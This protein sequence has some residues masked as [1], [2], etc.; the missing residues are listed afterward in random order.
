V[1]LGRPPFWRCCSCPGPKR[2]RETIR[3]SEP[4]ARSGR[5]E[6]SGKEF[7]KTAPGVRSISCR[8]GSSG[9]VKAVLAGRLDIGLSARAL[10]GE[11]R[12]PGIVETKYARPPSCSASTIP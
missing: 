6:S 8:N 11:E 5:C 10:S 7:R 1:T 2:R 12:A 9:S 3:I 4:A